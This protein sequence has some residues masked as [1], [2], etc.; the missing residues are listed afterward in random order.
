[1]TFS[2]VSHLSLHFP[3]NLSGDDDNETKIY[4]IGL[5]GDFTVAQRTGVV[6]AV[7]EAR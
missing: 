4:Y 6:H 3:S 2:N 7:Y 5:R 1:M